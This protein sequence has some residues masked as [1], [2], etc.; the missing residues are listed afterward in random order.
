MFPILVMDVFEHTYLSDD[1]LGRDKYVSAFI[2]A[3]YWT[4]VQKRF[5][6]R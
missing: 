6:G 3:I 5:G 1:G 2:K 4:E